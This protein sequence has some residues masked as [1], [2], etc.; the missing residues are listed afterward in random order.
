MFFKLNSNAQTRDTQQNSIPGTP[1][2][3]ICVW[4]VLRCH[5]HSPD[6]AAGLNLTSVDPDTEEAEVLAMHQIY[7]CPF[8]AEIQQIDHIVYNLPVFILLTCNV[9]FLIWIMI[10]STYIYIKFII[11]E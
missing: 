7:E 5:T 9:F 4:A 10:V 1:V 3:N 2:L 6:L 8:F 11:L